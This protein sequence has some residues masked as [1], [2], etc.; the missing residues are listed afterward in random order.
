MQKLILVVA[1]VLLVVVHDVTAGEYTSPGLYQVNIRTLENGMRVVSQSRNIAHEV[2]IVLKVNVGMDHFDCVKRDTPHFLEHLLFT[3]TSKHDE[4]E[5]ERWIDDAG[6]YANATTSR[7]DTSYTISIYSGNM[8]TAFAYL[9][10]IMTDSQLSEENIEKTRNI[11]NRE[12]GGDPSWI[13]M[14]MYENGFGKTAVKKVSEALGISCGRLVTAND[15]TRDDVVDAF[16]KYYDPENMELVV[17][18][19]YVQEDLDRLIDETMGMIVSKNS[20]RHEPVFVA[21]PIDGLEYRFESTLSPVVS[22][23]EEVGVVYSGVADRAHDVYMLRILEAYLHEKVFQEVRIDGAYAYSPS[24]NLMELD[25]VT[26]WTMSAD[27]ESGMANKVESLLDN[28]LDIFLH[29]DVDQKEFEGIKKGLLYNYATYYVE[30]SDIASHYADKL[31]ELDSYGAFI[32]DA[33]VIQS[34]SFAD[35]REAA[36]SFFRQTGRAAYRNKPTLTY[37]QLYICILAMLVMIAMIG[38]LWLKRRRGR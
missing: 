24:V 17:V 12:R 15:V 22:T 16:D 10:E 30:N 21:S 31:W 18:G 14:A 11:I 29:G 7:R 4:Y 32:D 3:G 34:G 37:T 25:D 13:R 6:G 26:V 27:I 38:T 2:S 5:L 1:I 28:E 33:S 36:K 19:D 35:V 8:R 23:E 9:Y 20:S